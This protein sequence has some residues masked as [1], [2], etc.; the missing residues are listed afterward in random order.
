MGELTFFLRLQVKQ[1]E[2][3]IFT[4]QD[5]YVA[6]ILKKFDFSYVK[7]TSTPIETQKPLVKDKEATDVDVHLNRSMIGS[8][9]YLMAYRPDIMFTVFDCSRFQVTPKLSH[10][11]AVKWI[12]SDY[13]GANLD[14]KSTTGEYVVAA[15]CCDRFCG[16]KIRGGDSL[17]RAATTASLDAQ[18][19]SSNITKTQSKA[20]LNEPTPQGEGSGS[21]PRGHTP[22]SNEGSMTLKELIDLCTTLLQKVLDLENVKTAQAKE[23]ANKDADTKMI[24]EDN[25]NGEKGGSKAETVSTARPDISAARSIT[26][27]QPLPTIN[28]KD[29]GKGILQEPEPIKKSNKMDQDQIERDDKVTLKIQAHLNEEVKI[30]RE[31]QEEASKAD[32]AE[33]YDEVQA[34][35]DVD[36]EL[37][38][39]LTHDE[40]EKSKP[41][42]KTQ[43]RNLMMTYLKHTGSEKDEKRIRS[44]KKRSAGTNEAGDVHVYKLTR[45]DGS[46][47]HFLTF[48]RMLE[49][50]NRQD[51]LDLHKTIMER[52]PANDPE[53]YDLIL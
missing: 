50:L 3:G 40:Q 52:L 9:M 29:K 31:R 11:H 26:R 7:T 41:P 16:F 34:Q 8:L 27:L 4:I 38:V 2:E 36:H 45:L 32:L 39:T 17:V 49:V 51:V 19:D 28:P 18:Q 12:F 10:L 53:G 5:K 37:A 14:R 22:R 1:S 48:S 23:I 6:E 47:K 21:G 13:A 33:M 20:T 30:E 15:N 44:R 42:T 46:Y 35:I 24:V 43:L 25:G